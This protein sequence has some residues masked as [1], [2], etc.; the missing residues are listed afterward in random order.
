MD[1]EQK[2]ILPHG[3]YKNLIAYHKSETIYQD[4]VVFCRRFLPLYGNRTVDQ[5][6]QAAR[7]C[8]QNIVEGSVASGTSKETELRLT[9]VARASLD[10]LLED[11]YDW[12]K[13]HQFQEWEMTDIRKIAAREYA[14]NNPNWEQWKKIFDTRP[15]ETLCNLMIV[16]IF[17]TK[18]LLD[19]ML[20]RQTTDLQTLGGVRER[21]YNVRNAERAA[22]WDK[23]VFSRLNS[24]TSPQQLNDFLA[25]IKRRADSMA[26][27]I[28]KQKGW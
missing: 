4:T 17:Q 19:G 2:I 10:E 28:R 14:L 13:S 25:E 21:I 6:T 18:Y 5:M 12:L 27:S 26:W 1:N 3:S 7:S 8:K 15:P 11:Y 23:S 22:G 20:K 16:L 9:N 24:A